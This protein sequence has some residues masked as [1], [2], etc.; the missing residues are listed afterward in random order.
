M[1]SA[2]PSIL[3]LVLTLSRAYSAP[4]QDDGQQDVGSTSPSAQQQSGQSQNSQGR[5]DDDG[6]DGAAAVAQNSNAGGRNPLVSSGDQDDGSLPFV[7]PSSG[8]I[9]LE[10]PDHIAAY[11]QQ[12]RQPGL[13]MTLDSVNEGFKK[14]NRNSYKDANISI[15]DKNSTVFSRNGQVQS[16]EGPG[17]NM[18]TAVLSE[19]TD[20]KSKSVVV[21]ATD[22]EKNV[23]RNK[24]RL[25]EFVGTLNTDQFSSGAL[26][27]DHSSHDE[28]NSVKQSVDGNRDT[29]VRQRDR[30]SLTRGSFLKAANLS[31]NAHYQSDSFSNRQHEVSELV[32]GGSDGSLADSS[33]SG[34]SAGVAAPGGKKGQDDDGD[35]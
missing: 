35:D 25:T 10:K 26:L 23:T 13:K 15:K 12:L 3:F 29:N 20:G 24:D 14:K 8:D 28:S 2:G 7:L 33:P 6:S 1:H 4:L 5:S 16:F 34:G 30:N 32:L 31:I 19:D 17:F 11:L 21:T 27:T 18:R 9:S 22:T